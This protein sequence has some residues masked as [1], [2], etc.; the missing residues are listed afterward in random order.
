MGIVV[1]VIAAGDFK[2]AGTFGT[3]VTEDQLA[4]F[5]K[6]VNSYN[7]MF[8]GG[9]MD[10]RG[11]TE[12]QVDAVNNGKVY[13]AREAQTLGLIDGVASFS[14]VLQMLATRKGQVT[15]TSAGTTVD[16]AGRDEQLKALCPGASADFRLQQLA[17]GASDEMVLAAWT[18][19]QAATIVA[20]TA[21]I[22]E[23]DAMIAD[24]SAKLAE[25]PAGNSVGPEGNEPPTSDPIAEWYSVVNASVSSGMTRTQ[26]VKH[27]ARSNKPLHEAFLAATA[28]R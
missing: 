10:G 28:N 13:L 8:R 19:Q 12:E 27:A 7:A 18:S 20:Q 23:R 2:G 5:Q 15:M 22:A 9:V 25:P 4:D 6:L 21:V 3:V 17:A 26:A 1:H 16:V 11:M 24:L 14:Q